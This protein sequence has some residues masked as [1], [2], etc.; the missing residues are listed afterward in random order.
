[1]GTGTLEDALAWVEYCNSN[2]DTY[3]ANLRRQNGREE[4]YRVKYWALGNEM[5]GPWQIKQHTKE[6]YAKKAIQGARALK[7]LDPS[8]QL[9]L[10]GKDGY[11]DWDRYTLQQCV[12]WVDM[13]SIHYYSMGKGHYINISSVY[14]AERAI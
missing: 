5:W 14:G 7:L 4:P 2:K 8:I 10:C 6:N 3:F 9:I 12:R 13:H 1:M 11:S